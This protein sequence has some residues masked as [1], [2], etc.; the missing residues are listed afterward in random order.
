MERYKIQTP[1]CIF[2]LPFGLVLKRHQRVHEQ[3]G[4]AMNLARA[5]GV[6][7]PRFLSFGSM[8]EGGRFSGSRK[9]VPS[10]LMTRVPGVP[11]DYFDPSQVDLD[12]VVADLTGILARMRSFASPFG[13]AVCGAAGGDIRGP[14]I[15]APPVA[16]FADE[17]AFI[18]H[19]REYVTTFDV[20]AV[21]DDRTPEQMEALHTHFRARAVKVETRFFALPPHAIVF[22]HGD[23]N[24]QNIMIGPD[25]H[26]C[27][28]IDW[29]AA[30]W[31]PEYWEVSVTAI[32]PMLPWG[33]VMD[34]KVSE[35]VYEQE[36]E[37]HQ[38]LQAYVGMSYSYGL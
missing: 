21:Y 18:D 26:V 8:P 32:M 14:M 25:G 12:V 4:L 2:Q 9:P 11:L 35:G 6:P 3:E 5:M 33:K 17:A 24:M 38:A 16:P 10:I 36:V 34:K 37:G 20:D 13:A 23:L 19:L 22:T 1:T 27:G 31:L 7:A 29:E 28:I 15:P 30:A